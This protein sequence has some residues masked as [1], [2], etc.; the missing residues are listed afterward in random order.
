MKLTIAIAVVLLGL[1]SPVFAAPTGIQALSAQHAM[2]QGC[3]V[4][5]PPSN[6]I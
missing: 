2:L 3:V 1:A 5:M 4:A 6:P